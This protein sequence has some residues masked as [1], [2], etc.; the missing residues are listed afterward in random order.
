MSGIT[1]IFR[2]DETVAQH[3]FEAVFDALDHRGWD[4]ADVVALDQVT[5]GH[6]HSYTTPEELGERQPI[7]LDDLWI[8]FDG[9]IDNRPEMLEQLA[10]IGV[11][12]TPEISDAELVL[13]AY[14]AFGDVVLERLVGAF[15]LTIWDPSDGRLLVARDKTGIREL[16]YA[17]VGDVVVV[18]SE[19]QAILEHP[20]V[21]S[22]VNEGFVGELLSSYFVTHEETFYTDIRPVQAGSSLEVTA[23]GTRAESYWEVWNADFELDPSKDAVEQFRDLLEEAVACR[24]RAPKLPGIMMSGG[25]DSTTIACLARRRLERTGGIDDELHSFSL[26][27]DGVDYFEDEVDRI[28]SVVEHCDLESHTIRAND[29]YVLK[30]VEMYEREARESPVFS[31]VN[32]AGEKL[33]ERASDAGRNVTLTGIAGNLYDGSRLYYL[34]LVRQGRFVTFVRHALADPMPF[35]QLVL[36]YVLAQSS[37]RLGQYLMKR[38]GKYEPDV[39]PWIDP[40]FAERYGLADR[41]SADIETGIESAASEQLFKRYFRRA[42]PFE[43]AVQR[44]VAL[45]A[46]VDLRCPYLDSRLLA[47]MV[48]LPPGELTRSG[49]DKA[50]FREALT[51]ILPEVVRTHSATVTFDPLVDVGILDERREFVEGLFADSKLA[52]LGIVDESAFATHVASL[53]EEGVGRRRI[54]DLISME[55]WLR[56]WT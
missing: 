54:W 28:N 56:Q 29:H 34:D 39:P 38:T 10:S 25:L 14:H 37:D 26:V 30:D 12:T 53:L 43:D 27:V 50:L 33:Y 31:P 40:E 18:A 35:G 2:R 7:A 15:A 32:Q 44:R 4:G 20:A 49:Q 6:Q 48:S 45:R 55:L 17:D 16:Y 52:E 11:G 21:S 51:G 5:L 24:L 19:M 47:F 1:A 8:T 42:R 46:G 41:V 3:E 23:E 9:R 13:R 22:D 36:W